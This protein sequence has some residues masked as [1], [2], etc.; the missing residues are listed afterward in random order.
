MIRRIFLS[1]AVSLAGCAS[2]DNAGTAE[3]HVKPFIGQDGR[4]VCCDVSVR[5]GKQMQ[6]LD[7]V[8]VKDGDKYTVI[9]QQRGV[10]AFAG[11]AIA[12]GAAKTVVDAAAK[13][14]VGTVVAPMAP[15]VVGK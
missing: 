8:I 11:Q 12:A 6:S 10:E 3:Y 15:L 5:N 1:L 7:A 13:A 9:L 14:A 2:L 4:P